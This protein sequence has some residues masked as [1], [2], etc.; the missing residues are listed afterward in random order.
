MNVNPLIEDALS[1]IGCPV[2]PIKYSG[3][4]ESYITYY[5]LLESD[6]IFADDIAIGAGTEA[7]VDVYSKGNFKSLV[8]EVK[9]KLKQ[10]GFS[11]LPSGLELYEPETGYYHIVIEIYIEGMED[12]E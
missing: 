5:T 10:A 4:S 7:T 6:E 12:E 1:N 8:K 3:K 2:S 9:K 11:I